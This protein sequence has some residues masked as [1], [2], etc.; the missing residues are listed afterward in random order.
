M[1]VED[2]YQALSVYA[3]PGVTAGEH[4]PWSCVTSSDA[5]PLLKFVTDSCS[6]DDPEWASAVRVNVG[7][8]VPNPAA[9][10]Q[11][12]IEP[13]PVS[14]SNEAFCR[15]VPVGGGPGT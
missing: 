5:A 1:L 14:F 9:C 6:A 8:L 11:S 15:V 10:Q 13:P 4:W 3:R 12:G 7:V 2:L